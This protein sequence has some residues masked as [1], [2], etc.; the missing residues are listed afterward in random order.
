MA[1]NPS[2]RT[3]RTRNPVFALFLFVRNPLSALFLFGM[4]LC[5]TAYLYVMYT[6]LR[7]APMRIFVLIIAALFVIAS[8]QQ[9]RML[10][11]RKN[12]R[13]EEHNA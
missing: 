3:A 1:R 10:I 11:R 4:G 13:S 8:V 6:K 12:L 5:G 9:V 7:Q 2:M